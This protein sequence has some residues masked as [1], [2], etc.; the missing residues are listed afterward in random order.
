MGSD[1]SLAASNRISF[2]F[3]LNVAAEEAVERERDDLVDEVNGIQVVDE[4]QHVASALGRSEHCRVAANGKR[5]D[6][7]AGRDLLPGGQKDRAADAEDTGVVRHAVVPVD[8][9]AGSTHVAVQATAPRE[10]GRG[11]ALETEL[12]TSAEVPEQLLGGLVVEAVHVTGVA[13][14]AAV[15]KVHRG[16]VVRAR[17][18]EVAVQTNARGEHRGRTRMAASEP[19]ED[20]ERQNDHGLVTGEHRA[21]LEVRERIATTRDREEVSPVSQRTTE[22]P[23]RAHKGITEGLVDPLTHIRQLCHFLTSSLTSLRFD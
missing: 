12:L 10:V 22:E 4:A 23:A 18:E 7:R 3:L 17:D 20:A 16:S 9:I 21:A 19:Q 5:E 15:Q 13:H 14:A 8:Q 1:D 2:G 6:L 11:H